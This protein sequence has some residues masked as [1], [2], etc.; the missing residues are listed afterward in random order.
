MSGNENEVL[1][2][3]WSRAVWGGVLSLINPGLGQ[4][5]A[6][7]WRLG[8]VLLSINVLLLLCIKG[9][10]RVVPPLP[11][12]IGLYCG[13]LVAVVTL[14]CGAAIDAARRIRMHPVRLRCR[15]CRD[16]R[17]EQ[18]APLWMAIILW[19]ETLLDSIRFEYPFGARG[20][21]SNGR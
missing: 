1:R 15:L 17:R 20:R 10:T 16:R 5:Y 2:G 3:S 6:R 9:L 11:W 12:S 4:V 8:V 14:A 21:Y 18:R 19:M 13:L 7:S